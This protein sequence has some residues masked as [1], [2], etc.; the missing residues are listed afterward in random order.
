MVEKL[1]THTW[2]R[3]ILKLFIWIVILLALWGIVMGLIVPPIL[4]SVAEKQLSKNL[5]SNCTLG[6]V[7]FNPY[8]FD[9]T[10]DKL[11]IPLPNGKEFFSLEQ[12][13]VG[14]SPQTIS[15]FAPVISQL[16]FVRPVLD[17][18]LRP[19]GQFSFMDLTAKMKEKAEN[20]QKAQKGKK[21]QNEE[22]AEAKDQKKDDKSLFGIVV[23]YFLLSNG[24]I[25][26]HDGIRKA[27][28][29]IT[30]LN[31]SVPFTST[32]RHHRQELMNVLF[33]AIVNERPF[34]LEGKL[35]PFAD[36]AR[37]EFNI[38]LDSFDLTRLQPYLVPFT[39]VKLNKG[40]FSSKLVL[41]M[42]RD[43][44]TGMRI[45]LKGSSSV[46]NLEIKA[47]DGK[48]ALQLPKLVVDLDGS[49]NTQEGMTI[50]TFEIQGL[51]AW[52]TLLE[53]GEINWQTWIKPQPNAKPADQTDKKKD[54]EAA[55]TKSE[56]ALP[57]HLKHFAFKDGQIVLTD[58]KIVK[59][60]NFQVDGLNITLD[61][62]EFPFDKTISKLNCALTLNKKTQ[63]A[64]DGGIALAPLDGK[65]TAKIDGVALP[66]FQPYVNAFKVPLTLE[67]GTFGCKGQLEVSQPQKEL[68]ILLKNGE[69]SLKT[70]SVV[71]NDTR[72][73]FF[74]LGELA[75]TGIEVN[76]P[77]QQASVK[78][79]LID[80]PDI[81]LRRLKNGEIDLPQFGPQG[82]AGSG[83]QTAANAEKPA[84]ASQKSASDSKPWQARVPDIRLNRGRV[85]VTLDGDRENSVFI[86]QNLAAQVSN[87]DT[88]TP[89]TPLDIKLSGQNER[90]GSLNVN[91]KL[92]P[93]PLDM[94]MRI[95]TDK[96][97][98]QPFSPIL[99]NDVSQA[100]RLRSGS[101]S[102]ALQTLLKTTKQGPAVTV[103]GQTSLENLSML[104]NK[105]EFMSLRA[106]NLQDMDL[107]T[108]RQRYTIGR[109][110][111]QKPR[112]NI[113]LDAK[114]NTN[115]AALMPPDNAKA[116]LK[117][118]GKSGGKKTAAPAPAAKPAASGPQ[119][120]MKINL[121]EISDGSAQVKD[122]GYQPAMIQQLD[123]LKLTLKGLETNPN[124]TAKLA[125]SGE[126]NH[127]PLQGEGTLQPF[128]KDLTGNLKTSLKSLKMPIFSPM[129]SRYIAYPLRKG[130][131]G[132][133]SDIK[134]K[135]GKLDSNHKIRLDGLELGKKVPSPNA[136]NL[137]IELG[138]KL[139]KDVSGNIHLNLPV[140][141]D[142]NDPS[143]SIGGIVL[144]TLSN[145]LVKVVA[146]PFKMV[147]GM[148]GIGGGGGN[149][150]GSDRVI[151][152]PGDSRLIANNI[153]HLPDVVKLMKARNQINLV[154]EPQADE[155]DRQ[156]LADAYVGR[157]MRQLKYESLS[158]KER[159]GVDP[160]TLDVS[161]EHDAEEY[162]ELLFKVYAEQSF[163]KAKGV[164]G[165]VKHLPAEEM[166]EQIR[167]HF[168]KDD[169]ALRQLARE[170]A[171]V[172]KDALVKLSPDLEKRISI[173]TPKVPG[174]GH[175]VIF[176]VK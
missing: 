17:V 151:F 146:S 88:A 137:P 154:L 120:Y 85:A 63:L 165:R 51:K 145:L 8:T 148:I 95:Q 2:R 18:E 172:L 121:L 70:L 32:L 33:K 14:L 139:L 109:V 108:A 21:P 68:V 49:V 143:F 152:A 27:D 16:S 42:L 149:D 169:S 37:T 62:L 9:L 123:K 142:L 61:D 77:K 13:N 147:G 126:F 156:N 73:A 159:A 122:N 12:F 163:D 162:E 100:L 102:M 173:G 112:V 44:K 58:Q 158:K 171:Q 83:A 24:E 174:E 164:F 10:L 54:A 89:K 116:N 15:R 93:D 20:E 115:I 75:L 45:G 38:N 94:N 118:N 26:F 82:Q 3:R 57:I 25:K 103:K 176:G 140:S 153:H 117:S 127:A 130:T 6:K 104:G 168:V 19:N 40:T 31:L 4:R 87:F 90:G 107:D 47:P 29:T 155:E 28:H 22:K 92:V 86:L 167:A 52:L 119:P 7:S 30:D 39:T 136:P 111:L 66:D 132:L 135:Q 133:E 96:F 91:G 64:V 128:A 50:N 124:S 59:N 11:R 46:D 72:Q 114:G 69:T 53:N 166:L 67:K 74:K 34:H 41:S 150:E 110:L 161:V 60:F 106:M 131:F 23:N 170:R 157:R 129:S 56:P 101:L 98:L 35:T 5:G 125:F 55:Q 1:P 144:K 78:Q 80:Q 175:Q 134:L 65:L 84:A 141:G 79:L 160:E 99:S 97:N 71:R 113:T 105:Q 43:M 81:Q 76:V 36:D 48:D 138:L